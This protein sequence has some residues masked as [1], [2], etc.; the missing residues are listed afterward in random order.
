MLS[1]FAMMVA[2]LATI[3]LSFAWFSIMVFWFDRISRWLTRT[4]SAATADSF[5]RRGDGD[6]QQ[7][8]SRGMPTREGQSNLVARVARDA[9]QQR[10]TRRIRTTS[11][12]RVTIADER[13]GIPRRVLDAERKMDGRAK[14]DVW[15]EA[16]R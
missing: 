12:A 6:D 5:R 7:Q 9:R 11:A 10:V 14:R 3:L 13:S 15:Q 16:G 8:S 2:W 4:S 1:W